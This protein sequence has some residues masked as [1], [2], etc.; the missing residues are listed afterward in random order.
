[1]VYDKVKPTYHC[2]VHHILEIHWQRN[3]QND[4]IRLT[5]FHFAV[6]SSAAYSKTEAHVTL[7]SKRLATQERMYDL[8]K[9][10]LLPVLI[11]TQ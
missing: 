5:L 7:L 11:S 9:K 1:M 8:S 4:E 2:S 10:A 6:L 3:S